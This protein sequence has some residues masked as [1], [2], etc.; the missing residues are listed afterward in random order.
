MRSTDQ[1]T[2]RSISSSRHT[3]P[4]TRLGLQD[5]QSPRAYAASSG[6]RESHVRSAAR[7]SPGSHQSV[8][9][10][11]IL[12][13]GPGAERA[14]GWEE[15]RALPATPPR[16]RGRPSALLRSRVRAEGAAQGLPT[17]RRPQGSCP[18][19]LGA[20]A[21]TGPS[22]RTVCPGGG[23][24]PRPPQRPWAPLDGGE[25]GAPGWVPN[26]PRARGVPAP[27]LE[28]AGRRARAL[29][30][31][32]PPWGPLVRFCCDRP[33]SR[34]CSLQC[35]VSGFGSV[36]NRAGRDLHLGGPGGRAAS[37]PNTPGE[38]RERPQR[39]AVTQPASSVLPDPGACAR[40]GL[41]GRGPR[42]RLGLYTRVPRSSG[43]KEGGI[44]PLTSTERA[45]GE[46]RKQHLEG[47]RKWPHLLLKMIPGKHQ[48][49]QKQYVFKA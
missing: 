32:P 36:L 37:A 47:K 42:G 30:P 40:R 12:D 3:A 49:A 45:G 4:V 48:C 26:V 21:L 9:H 22:P 27:Q 25:K 35:S 13:R 39:G 18:A 11:P 41:L 34:A 33:H 8:P 23:G 17:A 1:E 5:R 6:R 28:R 7:G 15:A 29:S 2:A 24:D 16:P 14:Q 19:R 44:K 38:R 10:R 43:D 20:H 31:G 46:G